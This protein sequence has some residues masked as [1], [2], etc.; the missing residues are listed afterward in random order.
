MRQLKETMDIDRPYVVIDKYK[1]EDYNTI[2]QLQ[3]QFVH[4]LMAL[5]DCV[6]KDKVQDVVY[7]GFF[8]KNR[9]EAAEAV[10]DPQNHIQLRNAFSFEFVSTVLYLDTPE[11]RKVFKSNDYASKITTKNALSIMRYFVRC[12]QGRALLG[13]AFLPAHN[14]HPIKVEI[15]DMIKAVVLLKDKID[16]EK[17]DT[18]ATWKRLGLEYLDYHY[19]NNRCIETVEESVDQIDAE[20]YDELMIVRSG[21]SRPSFGDMFTELDK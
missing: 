13:G 8:F 12:R 16:F 3:R 14:G 20:T 15:C 6:F 9:A 19:K 5:Y 10:K 17:T 18:F 4:L 11:V 2:Y 7:N 21:L 1:F